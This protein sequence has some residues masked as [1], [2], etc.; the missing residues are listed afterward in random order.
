MQPRDRLGDSHAA[1]QRSSSGGSS[2]SGGWPAGR[3]AVSRDSVC[4][5]PPRPQC[6][7]LKWRP[8]LCVGSVGPVVYQRCTDNSRRLFCR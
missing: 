2:G 3:S 5:A 4:C 6:G 1:A 7:A 8:Y